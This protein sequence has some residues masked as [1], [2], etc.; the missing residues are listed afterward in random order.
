MNGI[1][2]QVLMMDVTVLQEAGRQNFNHFCQC[3]DAGRYV[4]AQKP[5][6]QNVF[7]PLQRDD[8]VYLVLTLVGRSLHDLRKVRVFENPI[9][10][11]IHFFPGAAHGTLHNGDSNWRGDPDA[12]GNRRA[13]LNWLPSSRYVSDDFEHTRVLK[14]FF[15]LQQAWQLLHWS[16]TRRTQKNLHSGLRDVPALHSSRWHPAQAPGSR[17]IQRNAQIRS[18]QMPP[19]LN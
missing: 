17:R 5:K 19:G 3:I 7:V 11:L 9:S 15:P 12:R 13:T 18:P 10:D 1:L 16:S 4:S 6:F 2:L 14:I 8:F